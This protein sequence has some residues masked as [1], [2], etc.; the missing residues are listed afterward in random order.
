MSADSPGQR[1]GIRAFFANA[2]RPKKSR[3]VL[4]RTNASTPDLRATAFSRSTDSSPPVPSR[5]KLDDDVPPVPSLAPLQAHQAKYR[6]AKSKMDT[7]LGENLDYTTMLHS[8]GIHDIAEHDSNELYSE[9]DRRPPGEPVVASLS[10][11]LWALIAEYL[12][13]AEIASLAFA[14]K[15]LFN[16]L[17]PSAWIELDH[18][19]YLPYRGDFLASQ[20]RSLPH[21]LL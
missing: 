3:Q 11:D 5:G 4:R 14:S 6:T 16:R 19:D 13:P 20:D 21:H 17:G 9:Y 1:Q 12:N 10:F 18:F 8:L 7:Q 15:T 2:I